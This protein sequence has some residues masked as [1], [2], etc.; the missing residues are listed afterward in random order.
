MSPKTIKKLR[1]LLGSDI[2]FTC[3]DCMGDDEDDDGDD[4][5]EDYVP[6]EGRGG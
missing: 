5:Y 1:A 4:D 6:S 2:K 3:E